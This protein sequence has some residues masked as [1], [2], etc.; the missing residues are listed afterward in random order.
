MYSGQFTE[1]H[2]LKVITGFEVRVTLKPIYNRTKVPTFTK[3]T[4]SGIIRVPLIINL[5]C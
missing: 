2:R 4:V 1:I 5:R 3:T